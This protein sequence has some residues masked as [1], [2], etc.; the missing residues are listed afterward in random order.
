MGGQLPTCSTPT[1]DS[2]C[3]TV[4]AG[5]VTRSRDPVPSEEVFLGQM[6]EPIQRVTERRILEAALRI[7]DADG[8]PALNMRRIGAE[9][10]VRAM[11]LYRH[12]ANKEA[13]VAGVADLILEDLAEVTPGDD[14][15]ATA[16]QFFSSLR[17]ALS[18]HPNALPLVAASALQRGRARA[19]ADLVV[20]ALAKADQA[21]AWDS[22]YALASFTLG[23]AWME[24]GGFVGG[25]PD[26]GP[27]VRASASGATAA[28][29]VSDTPDADERFQRSLG[30]F[31]RGI[32]STYSSGVP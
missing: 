26:S 11:A 8:L 9:L 1:P 14:A 27:F 20:K 4:I 30:L 3:A 23:F 16:R 25:L 24:A 12:V 18:A 7:I 29:L 22:F 10:G 5:R 31:L 13:I 28:G 19:Q 21:D 32:A 2:G 15:T 17:T 6:A